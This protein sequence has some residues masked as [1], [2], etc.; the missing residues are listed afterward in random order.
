MGLGLL[1][2]VVDQL[3]HTGIR[4]FTVPSGVSPASALH[5]TNN[6]AVNPAEAHADQ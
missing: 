5:H 6:A 1:V 2:L 4:L 3:P